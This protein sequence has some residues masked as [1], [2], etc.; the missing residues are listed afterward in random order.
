[1]NCPTTLYIIATFKFE[2][3]PTV[4]SLASIQ[5]WPCVDLTVHVVFS[6]LN[7]IL[8]TELRTSQCVR[9]TQFTHYV[10]VARMH[11]TNGGIG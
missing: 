6:I 11:S 2:W 9:I 3:K 7:I 5:P 10:Q 8:T 1:M 4:C